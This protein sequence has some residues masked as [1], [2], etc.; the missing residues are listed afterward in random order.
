MIPFGDLDDTLRNG[1]TGSGHSNRRFGAK[2]AGRSKDLDG[3]KN[4]DRCPN[5]CAYRTM[6]FTP[7]NAPGINSS[8]IQTSPENRL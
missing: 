8:A 2:L 6:P 1:T 5:A 4:Q 3:Y 7:C